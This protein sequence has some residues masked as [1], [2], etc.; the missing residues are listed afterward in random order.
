M[1]PGVRFREALC[2][3]LAKHVFVSLILWGE[4]W[5]F[6]WEVLFCQLGRLC[7]FY[8]AESGG[9]SALLP[10][11][12][13]CTFGDLCPLGVGGFDYYWELGVVDPTLHPVYPWL[14]GGEPGIS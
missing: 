12:D 1:I 9:S 14:N 11:N 3:L 8:R 6:F 7:L 5:L 10:L 4:G 13:G 2:L